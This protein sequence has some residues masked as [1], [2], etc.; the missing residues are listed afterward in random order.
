MVNLVWANNF[1]C[2]MNNLA[3]FKQFI[4]ASYYLCVFAPQ[5]A[6]IHWHEVLFLLQFSTEQ[7]CVL[8]YLLHSSG[9]SLACGCHC[10]PSVRHLIIH[11]F[12][13]V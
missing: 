1:G 9:I 13:L 5:L 7:R 3:L 2:V 8:V 10:D 4:C 12:D 11:T 6:S